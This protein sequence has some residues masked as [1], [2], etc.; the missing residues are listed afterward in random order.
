M[1][2]FKD[3]SELVSRYATEKQP[4][5]IMAAVVGVLTGIMFSLLSSLF[6]WA[7]PKIFKI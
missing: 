2:F 7:F 6:F 5:Y 3:F 1:G 4:R